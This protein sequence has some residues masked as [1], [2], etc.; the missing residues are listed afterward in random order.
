MGVYQRKVSHVCVFGP[1]GFQVDSQARLR[2]EPAFAAFFK[3]PY[4]SE[5]RIGIT[6][7]RFKHFAVC[8]RTRVFAVLHGK[9][10]P[11]V[12]I[13]APRGAQKVKPAPCA[14]N[15][16]GL[17]RFVAS[18]ARVSLYLVCVSAFVIG[19][20]YGNGQAQQFVA[21][22]LSFALAYYSAFKCAA[23]EHIPFVHPNRLCHS[24]HK[25]V[26]CLSVACGSYPVI[27]YEF[28]ELLFTFKNYRAFIAFAAV[29]SRCVSAKNV[30]SKHCRDNRRRGN[31][32]GRRN[33]RVANYPVF[34]SVLL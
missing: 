32:R 17:R 1:Y 4:I 33:A 31:K 26:L 12:H 16:G 30:V 20:H 15:K 14:V 23:R 7:R 28:V 9:V 11:A 27:G 25:P 22:R 19:N 18:P 8:I 13:A 10:Q 29:N 5:A 2:N 21:A 3:H 6:R 24:C 34:H